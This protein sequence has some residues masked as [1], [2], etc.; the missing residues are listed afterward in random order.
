M[1]VVRDALAGT[2]LALEKS[3]EGATADFATYLREA[4]ERAIGVQLKTCHS[5]KACPRG[6]RRLY[7]RF[8]KTRGYEGLMLLLIAF[9]RPTQ[10]RL[11]L[12]P[13]DAA[14]SG[15]N[16]VIPLHPQKYKGAR[17]WTCHELPLSELAAGLYRSLTIPG[18]RVRHVSEFITP[19]EGSRRVEYE[20]FLRLR[21][22]LPLIFI[23]PER[24]HCAHDYSVEGAKWQ[25]KSTTYRASHDNFTARLEKR[26]GTRN[27]RH[28]SGPY[29]VADFD[30]LALLM[31]EGH[32]ALT[33]LSVHMFLIPMTALVQ[34]GSEGSPPTSVRLYPHR[35][36][37]KAE[38]APVHWTQ[39]WQIDLSSHS[40][41]LAGYQRVLSQAAEM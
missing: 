10:L 12:L 24:E 9:I 16:T 11:W 25:L 37:R 17:D 7:A 4:P 41:A 27:G 2:Q 5:F 19:D 35:A 14:P 28:K 6:R 36:V 34:H 38:F 30:W 20:A 40:S 22:R 29:A 23:E 8:Q 18:L 39:P 21:E 13:G 1:Q 32:P 3:A 33:E 15:A 26:S 31:P